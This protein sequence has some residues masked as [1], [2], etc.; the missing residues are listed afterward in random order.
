MVYQRLHYSTYVNEMIHT[1]FS[2]FSDNLL[3]TCF[4]KLMIHTYSS[5]YYIL[6]GQGTLSAE[7]NQMIY[8]IAI[9]VYEVHNSN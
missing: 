3:L 1:W 2:C 9:K 6:Y 7:V 8:I 5:P 4:V